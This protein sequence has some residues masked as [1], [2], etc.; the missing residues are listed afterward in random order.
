MFADSLNAVS[1][2]LLVSH[3]AGRCLHIQGLKTFYVFARVV[4]IYSPSLLGIRWY[5]PCL[6][7]VEDKVNILVK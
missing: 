4:H 3:S 1:N 2:D 5:A 6:L 7:N